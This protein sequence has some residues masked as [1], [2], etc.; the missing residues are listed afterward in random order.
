VALAER[1][2][3]VLFQ[4][5]IET[6]A[7]AKSVPSVRLL[8]LE[9]GVFTKAIS[10]VK[11]NGYSARSRAIDGSTS[12]ISSTKRLGVRDNELL[13]F[14]SNRCYSYQA[15]SDTNSDA[16]ACFSVV[17]SDRPLVRTGTQQTCPDHATSGGISAVAWEDSRGGVWWAAV[18]ADSGRICRGP[19]QLDASGTRPR[20]CPVGNVL[21]IY[22]VN[23]QTIKVAICNPV[24]PSASIASSITI[25]VDDISSTNPSYDVV[26][27][28][29]T[30]SPAAIAWHE[31]ATTNIRFGYVD[32][33]GFLGSPA[34][35]H[36][37]VYRE[38][39]LLTMHATTPLG[40]AFLNVDGGNGDRLALCAVNSV[41][42]KVSLLAYN[43]G[44]S[45]VAFT[46]VTA[47]EC[48][49]AAVDVQRIAIAYTTDGT[50][51][52]WGAYEEAAAQPS[53]RFVRTFSNVDGS[54]EDTSVL[55][56][57]GLASRAFQVGVTSDVFATFVHDTTYFN[58][59]VT[60]RISGSGGL[61]DWSPVGRM[62]PGL[63]G[64]APTRK[65]LPSVYVADSVVSIALP[66]KE[67]LLSE[68]NDQFTETGI[69]L[70]GLD[71]D[72]EDT[73]Q[74]AQL[75]RG[76][77]MGGCPLH[78][79]GSTW[80]EQG[81]HFGPELITAAKAGGGSLTAEKTYRYVAWYEW[82]D[83]LGEVH[84]GP[85]SV[86]T[87]VVL[88]VGETQVTLTL[89]TLRVTKKS[90]VRICVARSEANSEVKLFRIT[91]ADPSTAGAVNGYVANDTTVDTVTLVDRMSDTTL[92][93]QEPLYT[94]G[95]ILSNDPSPLGHVIAGGK[96]RLFF[97]D[98]SDGNLVR[99]SQE[100]EDG[101]GVEFPPEL[102]VRC[103]PFGGSIS[104]IAV[105]DDLVFLFKE[106]AIFVFGGNGPSAA[107]D[108]SAD[109]FS[110]PQ[111]VTS[112]V[113]CTD[114][115]SIALTPV[116]LV[117]K[118]SKG[119]YLLDRGR[120]VTYV[121]A[122]VETYN[123]QSVRRATVLPDR[124]AVVFLTDSGK[125]LYYDYLFGQWSTFTNHEGRDSVIVE[126][127]YHY[128]RTDDRVLRET[129][130]EYSDAGVPIT[131]VME[132]A[133]LHLQEHLQG[134]QM[135]W[136]MLLLGDRKSAHQLKMQY[137][138]DYSNQWSEPWYADATGDSSQTGWISGAN[139]NWIGSGEDSI[140]GSNYGD[141]NYGD[142]VFGGTGPGLY[143][144]RMH[145]GSRGQSIQFRFEDYQK[146]GL[147]GASFEL[148]ELV[149]TGGVKGS[150]YKPM[151]A[152]RS[153]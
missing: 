31:H 95:G 63:A 115:A 76:L 56:S 12:L 128:L 69:R 87:V 82:T 29:R 2:L 127:V 22:W 91:S 100:L 51:T 102:F 120:S 26:P 116:G 15:D 93:T 106:R 6:K 73:H 78:Y 33:G 83:T 27:T 117:F 71:F 108:I 111:L 114:P 23:G 140:L 10:I 13:V 131:F 81:F 89:P 48:D 153:V 80:T 103:D 129:V 18:D 110:L 107:G 8:A 143:Q 43:G 1:T 99:F 47:G 9:N 104:A 144:W 109:G 19:E 139:V 148:T 60:L 113:G 40:I 16:G 85:T 146:A 77:Y 147:A 119:I 126:G 42:S 97:V 66:Y 145:I 35:G 55:R 59:Y 30:G 53:N 67:R 125:T 92:A 121:G 136:H 46:N 50:K 118:S 41:T 3:R 68:N 94:N 134:F 96:N 123:S 138:T 62:L 36:P 151:S 32:G 101:Y 44:T 122:P 79:D 137:R 52:L 64:G 150:V 75:G 25:L 105:M 54:Q 14:T 49:V 84:R 28:T 39:S 90:N 38:S 152:G 4:G 24:T 130:N 57:V 141:G 124:T 135:F 20:C 34:S 37:S 74:T 11:R 17:P 21:H 86:D 5:G 98:P 133:W 61:S 142:G 132:T 112:D 72:N 7:D 45:L 149:L 70:A 65:Q 88:G 58:T